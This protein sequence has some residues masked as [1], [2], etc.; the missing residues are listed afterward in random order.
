MDDSFGILDISGIDVSAVGVKSRG[1]RDSSLIMP[2]RDITNTNTAA[3]ENAGSAKDAVMKG[4]RSSVDPAVANAQR[5]VKKLRAQLQDKDKQILLLDKQLLTTRDQLQDLQAQDAKLKSVSREARR[6]ISAQ[7]SSQ[8]AKN[9]AIA[10]IE[11]QLQRMTVMEENRVK[12]KNLELKELALEFDRM[13]EQY[14]AQLAAAEEEATSLRGAAE[15]RDG[16]R[17]QLVQS[18]AQMREIEALHIQSEVDMLTAVTQANCTLYN[19][20]GNANSPVE[21]SESGSLKQ[22]CS[23]L[24]QNAE[25]VRNEVERLRLEVAAANNRITQRDDENYSMRLQLDHMASENSTLTGRVEAL[26]TELSIVK[27]SEFSQVQINDKLV[28]QM[29]EIEKTHAISMQSMQNNIKTTEDNLAIQIDLV[30]QMSSE[31]AEL[32]VALGTAQA[33]VCELTARL[34]EEVRLRAE[35]SASWSLRLNT[36]EETRKSLEVASH[37]EVSLLQAKLAGLQSELA[38]VTEQYENDIHAAQHEIAQLKSQMESDKATFESLLSETER[39]SAMERAAERAKV[40]ALQEEIAAERQGRYQDNEAAKEAAEKACNEYESQLSDLSVRILETVAANTVEMDELTCEYESKLSALSERLLTTKEEYETKIYEMQIEFDATLQAIEE[41]RQS[42]EASLVS[43]LDSKAAECFALTAAVADLEKHRDELKAR[44][45]TDAEA[46]A[47]YTND[48]IEKHNAALTEAH[49]LL[50]NK[51]AELSSL[52]R[53]KEEEVLA[54]KGSYAEQFDK[55]VNEICDLKEKLSIA[56][57]KVANVDENFDAEREAL[58]AQHNEEM[59][60]IHEACTQLKNER[61]ELLEKLAFVKAQH[62]DEVKYLHRERFDL[63]A[64]VKSMASAQAAAVKEAEKALRREMETL[65]HQL[66]GEKN[67]LLARVQARQTQLADLEARCAS[68][69]S[70]HDETLRAL[71]QRVPDDNALAL[72][73]AKVGK[74]IDNY[75]MYCLIRKC[76][77]YFV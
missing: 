13:E 75:Y 53:A 33:E 15:E 54:I 63:Q 44:I 72:D 24:L 18:E 34:Q 12:R 62:K 74:N 61:K 65:Q 5:E 73:A 23:E 58:R 52:L 1:R 19:V 4:R 8:R 50:E 46:F 9:V 21:S 59:R 45:A 57:S 40:R 16:L 35:D 25:A 28:R 41:K 10:R 66:Q 76:L 67:E 32:R 56:S 64:E 71:E 11:G 43:E 60:I 68:L 17:E 27:D 2:L 47:L 22:V 48:L 14:E 38:A 26:G 42:K 55:Y 31:N 6:M 3:N 7:E 36:M 77:I 30:R 39:K 29:A 51:S 37:D 49:A 20:L 69:Q 70:S